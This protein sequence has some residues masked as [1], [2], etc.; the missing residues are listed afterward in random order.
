MQN[1]INWFEIPA[2]D[3]DRAV[4]FYNTVLETEIQKGEFMGELQAFF[5]SD[6]TSVGGAIVK[7]D[8]LTPA[9]TG[10]LIYLNLGTVEH[11]EQA[12]GRVEASGG[13]T[14]MPK[15]DI[16][17]PGFISVIQDSEGNCIGLHAPKLAT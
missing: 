17:D 12:M 16:G 9:M 5:P 1:A 14:L 3:F 7:S 11:L 6:H 8:R 15:M 2:A 4:T 13:K 10:T